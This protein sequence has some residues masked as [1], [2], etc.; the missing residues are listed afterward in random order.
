MSKLT[1][2]I[3]FILAIMLGYSTTADLK[4]PERAHGHPVYTQEHVDYHIGKYQRLIRQ[5]ARTNRVLRRQNHGVLATRIK[6]WVRLA[7][8]E[9]GNRWHIS[10]ANNIHF[11]GLQ[12]KTKTWLGIGGG[13]FAPRADLATPIQQVAVAQKLKAKYG[14]SQWECTGW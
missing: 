3:L 5:Q 13:V 4:N 14:K 12:F 10:D 9:S 8:C 11:G 2:T 1:F 7:Y 6:P